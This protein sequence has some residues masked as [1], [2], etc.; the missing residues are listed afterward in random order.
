MNYR[1]A[2]PT[3]NR[4]SHC[5]TWPLGAGS[6]PVTGASGSDQSSPWYAPS[7]PAHRSLPAAIAL[8]T[9][10]VSRH[11][12][13][14]Q[15]PTR[16]SVAGESAL[17]IRRSLSLPRDDCPSEAPEACRR[18]PISW[19]SNASPH[20]GPAP[21]APG[22]NRSTRPGRPELTRGRGLR[23]V[24]G[25]REL[26]RRVRRDRPHPVED[27]G[28]TRRDQD[29]ARDEHRR[30]RLVPTIG[31]A[32]PG[33]RRGVGPDELPRADEALAVE[34]PDCSTSRALRFLRHEVRQRS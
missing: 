1:H 29:L 2:Q 10:S 19:C 34:R 13:G 12:P 7:E 33:C 3:T 8:G 30:D 22:Y 23:S 27:R 15:G 18:C 21:R 17:E 28:R 5:L 26:M 25:Y 31:P 14:R 24:A 6:S 9:P 20:P 4:C 11:S 32:H 16:L